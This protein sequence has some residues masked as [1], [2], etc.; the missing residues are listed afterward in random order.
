MGPLAKNDNLYMLMAFKIKGHINNK[1]T[2]TN[3]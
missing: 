3:F 1:K 2:L